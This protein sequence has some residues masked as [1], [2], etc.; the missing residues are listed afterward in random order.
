V[1]WVAIVLRGRWATAGLLLQ[2]LVVNV[3][4]HGTGKQVLAFIR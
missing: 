2:K 4:G 1:P 3:A